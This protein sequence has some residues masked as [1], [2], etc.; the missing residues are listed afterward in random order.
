[1]TKTFA[2]TADIKP[3]VEPT[4]QPPSISVTFSGSLTNAKFHVIGG[5][6]LPNRPPTNQGV[7]IRVVDAN[8]LVET[9]RE[10][11]PSSSSGKID[12]TVE[13]DISGLVVNALGVATIA[14]S[15]TDGRSNPMDATGFL[16]SNTVRLDFR[17]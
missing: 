12:H 2:V 1:L 8:A 15:A 14:F 7:A 11:V 4:P 6:F 5:D 9:R 17:Q 10:F 16:W 13:G 3:V